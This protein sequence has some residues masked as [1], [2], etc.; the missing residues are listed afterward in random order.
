MTLIT[1]V[2]RYCNSQLIQVRIREENKK[3]ELIFKIWRNL[4]KIAIH[5]H[6]QLSNSDYKHRFHKIHKVKIT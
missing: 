6:L 5:R 4:R 1:K 2:Y 3:L